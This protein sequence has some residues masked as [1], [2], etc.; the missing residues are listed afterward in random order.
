MKIDFNNCYFSFNKKDYL[1][2][3]DHFTIYSGEIIGVL[4]VNGA[5]KSTLFRCLTGDL[6]LSKGDIMIND[7]SIKS[8]NTK[9]LSKIISILPQADYVNVDYEV[10]L[11]VL[12]GITPHLSLFERPSN[13][14]IEKCYSFIDLVGLNSKVSARYSTLSTGERKLTAIAQTLYKDTEVNI[15]DEPTA[16]LDI[17]NKVKIMRIIK[18]IVQERKK[19]F[20][21]SSHDPNE[22]INIADKI[23]YFQN[24]KIN[25]I[26][27]ESFLDGSLLNN[28][29]NTNVKIISDTP[30][31]LSHIVFEY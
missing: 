25:I 7:N 8:F 23:I 15:F 28:I 26:E 20:L 21:I 24:K 14:E 3:C 13:E 1:F 18:K 5:G 17:F 9:E 4:G 19:I 6:T 11:L 29:F 2:F 30:N 10:L 27:K 16:N 31:N 12:M 22:I